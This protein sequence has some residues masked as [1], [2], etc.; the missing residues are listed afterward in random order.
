MR[1]HASWFRSMKTCSSRRA[2][3]CRCAEWAS[4]RSGAC[5]PVPQSGLPLGL[6]VA[7]ATGPFQE[8][9][10]SGTSREVK[11]RFGVN[12]TAADSRRQPPAPMA[13]GFRSRLDRQRGRECDDARRF[14]ARERVNP[15]DP[16]FETLGSVLYAM[17]RQV[18]PVEQE[19]TV[20]AMLLRPSRPS[21]CGR[22]R[23]P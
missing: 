15:A 22:L 9:R 12:W 1:L 16:R 4:R 6:R 10:M 23:R 17:L 8:S 5:G 11:R 21:P 3:L 20:V 19:R 7:E 18:L 2:I 14:R 13:C